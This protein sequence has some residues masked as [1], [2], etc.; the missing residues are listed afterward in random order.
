MPVEMKNV[1]NLG[2]VLLDNPPVNA[3]G[4]DIRQGLLDAVEWAE[5]RKLEG[6]I[7]TGAGIAFAAGA[8]AKELVVP[9]AGGTQRL[10]RIIG[11]EKAIE[12]ISS[13]K[14]I[15]GKQAKELGLIHETDDDPISF[16]EMARQEWLNIAVPSDELNA[17]A[18][19][20]ET[21]EKYRAIAAKKMRGQ[22]APLQ[23]IDLVNL[24]SQKT[25][26]EGMAEE[27]KIFLKLRHCD[28]AK[29][30][31]H[32]FFAERG[33]KAP[34]SLKKID[35][36]MVESV[37][38]V[39]GGT[40]GASIAYAFLNKNISVTIL[41]INDE[42]MA[43]AKNNV[44]EI[45]I[46][47]L[48]RNLVNQEKCDRMR[49]NFKIETDY[50]KLNAV[51]IVVE[52]G[53]E[54][55]DVKKEIFGKLQANLPENVIFATNTSYLDIDEIADSL[56][57]SSRLIGLHFFAPAHI[58]K[59]LEIVRG[60][61]SSDDALALGFSVAKKIAKIPVL[62]SVCDGFI[63]N[64]ILMRYREGGGYFVDGWCVAVAD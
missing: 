24:A 41:E 45:I 18:V 14:S 46:A 25:L 2:Y 64:R 26:L 43:R 60:A 38:V 50:S 31:R 20:P 56:D 44:E 16:A 61:N 27:R 23:A 49:A 8:D 6:V 1:G 21:L 58:M 22:S 19:M 53:F 3:I 9:G 59:L 15:S 55:L 63:G 5:A 57:N 33:A 28:E 11:T 32:I 10:P 34:K 51:D 52:A 4:K 35:T 17:D 48:K 47:S 39:G 30:L 62:A 54:S 13:G 37:V 40:M 36:P 29:A 7:V 12:L 42:A